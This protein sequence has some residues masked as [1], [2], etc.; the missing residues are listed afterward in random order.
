MTG[1]SLVSVTNAITTT[2]IPASISYPLF[3]KLK[4][5]KYLNI[6]QMWI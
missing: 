5:K 3:I 6:D 2:I 1:E 4:A